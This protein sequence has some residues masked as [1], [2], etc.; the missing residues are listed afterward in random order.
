MVFIRLKIRSKIANVPEVNVEKV[1]GGV[2]AFWVFNRRIVR[3][4][5]IF[6]PLPRRGLRGVIITQDVTN[7]GCRSNII[8]IRRLKRP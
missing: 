1:E 6:G 2:K 3:P 5:D 4:G 7:Y 8:G